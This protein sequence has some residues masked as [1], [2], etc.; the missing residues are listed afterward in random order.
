MKLT[1]SKLG[2]RGAAGR[3]AEAGR[4]AVVVTLVVAGH[5][6]LSFVTEESLATLSVMSCR[7]LVRPGRVDLAG[8]E[9]VPHHQLVGV[10]AVESTNW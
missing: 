7:P 8:Q 6:I 5:V 10:H 4:S 9:R 2:H 3:P 1:R